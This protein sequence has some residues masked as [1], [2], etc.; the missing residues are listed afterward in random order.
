MRVNV[1]NLQDFPKSED[2]E[3]G[4]YPVQIT[5]IEVGESKTSHA[6]QLIVE[7]TITEGKFMSRK[8]NHYVLLPSPLHKDGGMM[9]GS[10]LRT[11]CEVF[12]IPYDPSGFDTED[13]IGKQ[14]IAIIGNRT[15]GSGY[16]EVKKFVA[17]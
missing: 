14:A 11:F 3:P 16:L 8:I 1:G 13:A 9:A 5:K 10:R 6:P 4:R 7:L 15:D 12:G 17:A 2:L